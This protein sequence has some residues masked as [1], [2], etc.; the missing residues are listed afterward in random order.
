MSNLIAIGDYA[1]VRAALDVSLTAT[2][3]P[4]DVIEQPVF[5][6]AAIAEIVDR[7][8]DAES[9]IDEDK[10]ARLRRAAIYLTAARLAPAVVRI[11]S[12]NMQLGDMSYTRQTFDPEKRAAELRGL[13][14]IELVEVIE[15]EADDYARPTMFVRAPGGRAW[16]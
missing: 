8:E 16:W 12:I 13:A 15:P 14:E 9:E 7:Y 10:L 11:T 2:E 4:D 6:D 1:A 5:V 3:L